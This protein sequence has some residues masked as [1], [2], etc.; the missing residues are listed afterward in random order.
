MTKRQI[1]GWIVGV[2]GFVSAIVTITADPRVKA[3]AQKATTPAGAGIVAASLGLNLALIWKLAKERRR[4]RSQ[5]EAILNQAYA[6]PRYVIESYQRVYEIAESGMVHGKY[7][8]NLRLGNGFKPKDISTL[9]IYVKFRGLRESQPD[10]DAAIQAIQN[11][12]TGAV[13]KRQ[14]WA[15]EPNDIDYLKIELA[16]L[17]WA[18]NRTRIAFGTLLPHYFRSGSDENA[19]NVHMAL[20]T[21]LSE[22]RFR[23]S[24]QTTF[25]LVASRT[26]EID[27]EGQDDIHPPDKFFTGEGRELVWRVVRP[28]WQHHYNIRF[29]MQKRT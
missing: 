5:M 2:V 24:E 28:T 3:L 6:D 1:I 16:G 23:L 17:K 7:E 15:F 27:A 10:R 13:I 9:D 18:S 8:Y 29:F 22:I 21:E 12:L 14:S 4:R 20:R 25:R 19:E 26:I 11:S